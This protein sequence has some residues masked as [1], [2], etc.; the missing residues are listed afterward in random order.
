LPSSENM[1]GE[2]GLVPEK[3][4]VVDIAGAHD[5]PAIKVKTAVIAAD[6]VS[7]LRRAK[8]AGSG[9]QRVRQGVVEDK[10]RVVAKLL[11]ERGLKAVVIGSEDRFKEVDRV[12][13]LERT[14]QVQ[15]LRG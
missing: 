10:Q 13:T 7:V 12:P 14:N 11:L 15:P 6:V 8:I 1:S 9:A 5:V 3:G 4:Q 2:P